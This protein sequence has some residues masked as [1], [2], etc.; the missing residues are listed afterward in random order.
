MSGIVV[1]EIIA[2]LPSKCPIPDY[3][4]RSSL[5]PTH[6]PQTDRGLIH[7]PS[8]NI[9]LDEISKLRKENKELRQE[10][11]ELKV[12]LRENSGGKRARSK[13]IFQK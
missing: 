8:P 6:N 1:N 12:A 7:L 2:K 4:G 11:G 3:S 5:S 10:M 13:P 9:L